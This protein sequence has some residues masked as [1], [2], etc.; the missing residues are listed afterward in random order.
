MSELPLFNPRADERRG[1]ESWKTLIVDDEQGVH[2]VTYLALKRFVFQSRPLTFYHAYSGEEARRIMQQHPDMA[3]V[4]LDVVMEE[5]DA[6]LSTARYIRETLNNHFVR[7]ILRTGQPGA[8]PEEHV[9]REFDINDY[10]DKT[11]LTVQKLKTMMYSALRSYRDLQALEQHRIGL[12]KVIESTSDLFQHYRINDFVSGLLVQISSI[13]EFN[14]NI[15]AASAHKHSIFL[16]GHQ[17]DEPDQ[18][19]PRILSGIGRFEDCIGRGIDEILREDDL[20][21]IH[22]AIASGETVIEA[23]RAVFIFGNHRGDY[24]LVYLTEVDNISDVNRDLMKLFTQNVSIAY[25]NISLYRELDDTARELLLRLG[26]IAEFRSGETSQHVNRVA[27]YSELLALK[28]GLDEEEVHLI[29]M[30]S[31]M[32]D[33]GKLGIPD[34]IL[35]KPG[36][37]SSSEFEH[38]K[39]HC[40]IGYE[41]LKGSD[42]PLLKAAAI[43]AQQHQEKWDGSGYPCGL[44]GE[45]I[46]IY[47]RITALMDV[48][49]ALSTERCYKKAW[50]MDEVLQLIREQ[51]GKHFDPGLVEIFLDNLESFIEIRDRLA[52]NK[53]LN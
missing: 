35:A 41:M 23:D 27:A 30:A 6:G 48:F 12:H 8:A 33:I 38:M 53:L 22:Q 46:H 7:I 5:D 40:D 39:R 34:R 1:L 2:D 20:A 9:I 51:S 36:P 21:L 52:D 10:K 31:P 32:H 4:L 45:Q 50:H 17:S 15:L 24:G 37:L 16:A 13:L 44:A 11:E 25:E 29:R 28:A 49:D 3:L 42:R 18:A 14:S 43:I 26:N 47:G 19:S